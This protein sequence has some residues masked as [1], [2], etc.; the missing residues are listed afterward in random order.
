MVK[1]WA[2]VAAV[3]AISAAPVHAQVVKCVDASG[4]THYT[5]KPPPG[6]KGGAVDIKAAPPI[7][8][9]VQESKENVSDAEREFQRRRLD[10]ERKEQQDASK[11]EAQKRRCT[12]MRA[13]YQ[14]LTSARRVV[15]TNEKGERVDVDAADVERRVAQL[16]A[17]ISR[18]CPS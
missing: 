4:V 13:D 7:S 1:L 15:R 5:D 14:N 6:C 2:L 12:S 18:S 8:G 3:A 9:K 16:K 17:E 11:L 10:R